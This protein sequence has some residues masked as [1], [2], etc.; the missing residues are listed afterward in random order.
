MG[1]DID[2]YVRNCHDCQR[3]RS[4][5]HSIFGVLR[6]LSVLDKPL[7]DISMDFVVGFPSCEGFDAI[8]V[9]VDQL[10]K[11]RH[12][13]PYLTTIDALGLAELFLRDVVSL[14][15]LPL[16]IVSDRGPQLASTI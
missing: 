8:W 7:E 12:F 14:H 10:A 15:G 9:V 11:I 1:K 2:W 16:T 4:S 3:S 5:R 13:I 6:T